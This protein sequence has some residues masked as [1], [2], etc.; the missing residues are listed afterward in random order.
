MALCHGCS[1]WGRRERVKGRRYAVVVAFPRKQFSMAGSVAR[2]LGLAV[3]CARAAVLAAVRKK[4]GAG[5]PLSLGK[6]TNSG[7]YKGRR[8]PWVLGS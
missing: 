4:M 7:L 8:R 3:G 5:A 2:T 1:A 6:R